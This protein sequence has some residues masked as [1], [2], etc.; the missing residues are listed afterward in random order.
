MDAGQFAPDDPLKV[1]TVLWAAV[2]GM[3]SL[4]ITV[5]GFPTFEEAD[6]ILDR[7]LGA[8]ARGLAP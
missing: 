8:L 6:G 2:H 1:A 5:P 4:R 3:T 7:V